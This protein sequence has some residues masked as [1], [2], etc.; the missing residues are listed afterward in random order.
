MFDFT[1]SY[2]Y[3]QQDAKMFASWGVDFLKYDL[4]S[5]RAIMQAQGGSDLN[6]QR[7]IMEAAYEKMHRALVATGRPIVFSLCQ[8]RD[9]YTAEVPRHEVVMLRL[10]K[11]Q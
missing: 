10:S 6:K 2:G 9:T 8:Y 1:G 11:P 7:E 3:E 5:F 4:C